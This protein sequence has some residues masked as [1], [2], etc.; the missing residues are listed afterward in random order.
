MDLLSNVDHRPWPIPRGPWIMTQT[1]HNLLFA[2]WPIAPESLR[3]LVPAPLEIDIFEG[4]AWLGIIPFRLSGIRLHG[5]PEVGPVSHFN[6]VNVRTYVTYGGKR[7]VLFLSMDANNHPGIRMAKPWFRLPYTYAKIGFERRDGGFE[8]SCSRNE[9]DGCDARFD[10]RYRP[11][12]RPFEAERGTL[13]EWLTE[14]YCYYSPSRGSLY[15]CEI[16]HPRW[17][18]QQAEACVIANT[19]PQVL[20]LCPPEGE[21]SLMYAHRMKALIW[22][23]RKCWAQS[24]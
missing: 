9:R 11:C 10:C 20:G 13:A 8:I 19:L 5:T 4:K 22:P 14:R 1:W 2:H 18:L 23:I 15:R 7:G 6:E 12:G 21:P 24:A 17:R 3:S 16:H